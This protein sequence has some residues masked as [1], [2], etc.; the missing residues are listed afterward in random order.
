MKRALFLSLAGLA[1]CSAAS[2]ETLRHT[3]NAETKKIEHAFMT[4]DMN[5]F[6]KLMQAYATSDF[7]YV[8]AGKTM[9]LEDMVAGMKMSF[10]TLTKMKSSSST[11][12]KLIEKGDTGTA[13]IEHKMKALSSGPDKKV[14]V[15][16][17][18]G[19]STD[20]YRKEGGRW[21]LAS[22]TWTKQDMTRDG[23][24]FNPMAMPA[25]SGW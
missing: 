1:L 21:K 8:E 25:G 11:T 18:S 14:H 13:L 20:E 22:M 9:G 17:F 6:E 15:V 19:F 12:L 3:I 5:A 16:V 2:A 10:S 7:K 24:P 23:K 4:R